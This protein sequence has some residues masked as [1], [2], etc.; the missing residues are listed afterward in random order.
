[1]AEISALSVEDLHAWI[2]S[3]EWTA[4]ERQV[5]EH[6]GE[7][8]DMRLDTLLRVG[9]GYLNLDRQARTL[10]GGEAQRIQ[11]AAALGSG[12]TT[13]LYVLDEPTIGLH[14]SDSNRLLALLQD[15]ASRGNTVLVVEH[16]R[17]LIRGADHVIDLGPRA[18]AEG[19]ELIAEGSFEDILRS[20]RSLTARFMR[21]G[22]GPDGV[23]AKLPLA[24]AAKLEALPVI[25]IR[26]ARANNLKSIDV[27]VPVGCLV[28]VSGV[29]GCGKSSLVQQVLHANFQRSRGVVD[30]EPGPCDALEGVDELEDI[31]LVDQRPIGRSSR[32]NPVTYVKAYD[33]IRKLFAATTR[34]KRDRVSAGHFS[35]NVDKGRCEECQGTGI[36]EVDMHFMAAV[37]VVCE[38]CQGKR[39]RPEILAI[40]CNGLNIAETLEL[41]VDEA[42]EHFRGKAALC[43]R[44]QV[45]MDVGL[46][47]L[48]LGQPTSTLSGGEAQRLKLATF[49]GRRAKGQGRRLFL[50][51]EPTTGLHMSD[52]DLLHRTLRR[53]IAGGDGVVVVEHSLDLIAVADWIVDLGPG[54]GDAGGRVLFSGPRERFCLEG[55]GATAEELRRHLRGD[56]SLLQL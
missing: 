25:G 27:D 48:H 47:Y 46:G 2:D 12:L 6:L 22:G 55:E 34:A 23:S 36:Q 56:A 9:L 51:D 11:L 54:G 41:T 30:V 21:R 13:T 17:T 4:A 10:S 7:E 31:V 28:V 16:D 49:L 52:I 20:E 50:F 15:L 44:L 29:S 19:G 53:L 35:F 45:L 5:A 32:S 3:L 37:Q 33:E 43:R 14:P 18:G 38:R 42:R 24:D 8:L 39:F 26:G 40:T 1:M